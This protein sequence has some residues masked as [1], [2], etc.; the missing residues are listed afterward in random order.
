MPEVPDRTEVFPNL[1][2][3]GKDAELGFEGQVID[4]RV[5]VSEKARTLHLPVFRGK[6]G[7]WTPDP[8]LAREAVEAISVALG[9]GEKVLVRCLSGIER[10][11]A[12]VA[13]Y[14]V[15]KKGLTPREAY[16][17]IRAARPQVVEAFDV[18]ALMYEEPTRR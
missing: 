11:P 9:R 12:I 18:L 6:D 7:E 10:S 14:L 5:Q 2:V 4:L 3:G 8:V 16:T 15:Q 13:L 17:R 1:W